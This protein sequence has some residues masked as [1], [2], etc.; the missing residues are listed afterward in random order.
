MGTSFTAIVVLTE[1]R[2]IVEGLEGVDLV[3]EAGDE[4]WNAILE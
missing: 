2:V 1:M 3:F 4:A